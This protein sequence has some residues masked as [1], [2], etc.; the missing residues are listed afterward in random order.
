MIYSQEVNSKIDFII[1]SYYIE[2]IEEV[3]IFAGAQNV[4]QKFAMALSTALGISKL[5]DGEMISK[6]DIQEARDRFKNQPAPAY[7]YAKN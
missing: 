4:M 2:T 7:A 5:D 6:K 1:E 3:G